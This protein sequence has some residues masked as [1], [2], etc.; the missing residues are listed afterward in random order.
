M[1][2]RS[3]VR[4]LIEQACEEQC[5][6]KLGRI[7]EIQLDIGEFSGVDSTLF[8]SAFSEMALA[9]WG[10]PVGLRVTNVPLTAQ[11]E[12]CK[13]E[14]PVQR[15]Y[16]SCPNCKSG[17]VQLKNGEEIRLTNLVVERPLEFRGEV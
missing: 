5:S 8:E 17:D 15:F 14:F 4:T 6:R 7:I 1:H 16:F 13:N 12:S 9:Y 3:L 2:E 11:C 10:R